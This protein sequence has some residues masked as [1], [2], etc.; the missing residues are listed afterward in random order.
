MLANSQ[1]HYY[2]FFNYYF[3]DSKE[4]LMPRGMERHLLQKTQELGGGHY[5]ERNS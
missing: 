3:S 1:Q 5:G 2:F 4:L